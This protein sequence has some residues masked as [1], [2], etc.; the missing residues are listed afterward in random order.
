MGGAAQAGLCLEQVGGCPSGSEQDVAAAK[1]TL[2]E[3]FA[4]RAVGNSEAKEF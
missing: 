1:V 2:F 3:L 4:W